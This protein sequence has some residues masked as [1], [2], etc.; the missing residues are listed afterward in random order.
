MAFPIVVNRLI[1]DSELSTFCTYLDQAKRFQG[2]YVRIRG[3]ATT[4]Y[5]NGFTPRGFDMVGIGDS[6]LYGVTNSGTFTY[7]DG[8]FA[9]L[10]IRCQFAANRNTTYGHSA[11]VIGGAGFLPLANSPVASGFGSWPTGQGLNVTGTGGTWKGYANSDTPGCRHYETSATTVGYVLD[12]NG[13]ATGFS[14]QLRAGCTDFELVGERFS[15]GGTITV[16]LQETGG[17]NSWTHGT[18]WSQSGAASYA[19][20]SSKYQIS[21]YAGGGTVNSTSF[22]IRSETSGAADNK[23]AGWLV[24]RDDYNEGF[25]AHNF[26][27]SGMVLSNRSANSL[28]GI[29]TFFAGGAAGAVNGGLFVMNV[30]GYNE[31][32]A[33]Q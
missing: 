29:K 33:H 2:Q 9:T 24:Y 6:R 1:S 28:T 30:G 14:A 16:K 15:T 5:T 27:A 26:G 4:N 8:W 20:R 7:V 21:S 31:L 18:T 25:R 22:R 17:T 10:K 13:A 19:Y 11:T 32:Q 23:V 3:N 12:C